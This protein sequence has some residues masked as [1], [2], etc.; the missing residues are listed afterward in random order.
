MV[1]L[2]KPKFEFY[3]LLSKEIPASQLQQTEL[4]ALPSNPSAKGKP[5]VEI[6]SPTFVG[7]KPS[8]RVSE[9]KPAPIKTTY[10]VQVASFQNQKDAEKLKAT[11]ILKDY[12]AF[13]TSISQKQQT[14][15]RVI[16]GPYTSRQKAEAAQVGLARSEHIMGMIRKM[17]A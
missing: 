15:Y 16:I 13:I 10:L 14:W 12:K 17:D 1:D 6:A 4:K 7:N 5:P 8:K 9:K 2:N 11:L 3:T